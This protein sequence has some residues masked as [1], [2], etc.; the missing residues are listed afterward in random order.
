[1]VGYFDTGLNWADFDGEEKC[2][3]VETGIDYKMSENDQGPCV[4][5]LIFVAVLLYS[6]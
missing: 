4:K 1:V 5:N 6:D 3:D 2:S